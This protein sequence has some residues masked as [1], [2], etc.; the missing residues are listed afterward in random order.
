MRAV[1]GN[2]AAGR[3][4]VRVGGHLRTLGTASIAL[5]LDLTSKLAILGS[6]E[7]GESVS[8]L[9]SFFRLTYIRNPGGVFGLKFGGSGLHLLFAGVATVAVIVLLWRSRPEDGWIRTGL[10]LVLA[11]AVGNMV[12]RIAF[13]YVVDFIDIGCGTLRWYV[14]NLA[15]AYVTVGAGLLILFYSSQGHEDAE[16]DREGG[17]AGT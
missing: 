7:P 6:L 15:D 9:G 10:G 14:F 2:A 17:P 8:V 5:V 12:D 4:E 3:A 13:G 11:G 16:A 1:Q